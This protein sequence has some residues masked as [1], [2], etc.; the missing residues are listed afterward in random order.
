MFF[1][2][3]IKI[4]ASAD[5][6]DILSGPCIRLFL[7]DLRWPGSLCFSRVALLLEEQLVV[8]LPELLDV[9]RALFT[10]RIIKFWDFSELY[11]DGSIIVMSQYTQTVV[12][13]VFTPTWLIGPQ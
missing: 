6:I 8:L 13:V 4:T 11:F 2:F 10:V 1:A 7:M 9:E 12:G 3:L 5:H